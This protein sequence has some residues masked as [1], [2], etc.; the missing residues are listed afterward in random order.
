MRA[1]LLATVARARCESSSRRRVG[2][3]DVVLE[4]VFFASIE[5]G[6]RN[7]SLSLKNE[8]ANFHLSKHLHY[9]NGKRKL[10]RSL[11]SGIWLKLVA[12]STL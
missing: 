3:C 2:R 6:A 7:L 4:V 1:S 9:A 8:L 11:E 10:I 12:A 5:T